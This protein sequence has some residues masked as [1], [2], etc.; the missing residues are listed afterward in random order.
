MRER[1]RYAPVLKAVGSEPLAL[2]FSLV[3]ELHCDAIVLVSE[4]LIEEIYDDQLLA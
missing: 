1:S 4:E 2:D 3:P